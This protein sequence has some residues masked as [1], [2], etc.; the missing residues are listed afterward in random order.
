MPNG[1]FKISSFT[2]AEITSLFKKARIKVRTC[3]VRILTASAL[4]DLGRIL[5]VTP[6][7]SGSSPERNCFRRRI[8][9]IFREECFFEKK[10]DFVVIANKKGVALSFKR[11]KELLLRSLSLSL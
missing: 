4:R 11:L 2:K 7:K 9:A 5:I 10:V 3:E 6:R 1:A 8:K